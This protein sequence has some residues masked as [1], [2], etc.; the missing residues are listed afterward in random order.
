MY[1]DP[2]QNTYQTFLNFANPELEI[3]HSIRVGDIKG[4]LFQLME[5]FL[6]ISD[7][8][9]IPYRLFS[10]ILIGYL[11]KRYRYRLSNPQVVS[12]LIASLGYLSTFLLSLALTIVLLGR[13]ELYTF[14]FGVT[15]LMV[16]AI[17]NAII[18]LYMLT[19]SCGVNISNLD[20]EIAHA[21][22]E[23][24]IFEHQRIR[25]EALLTLKKFLMLKPKI[26]SE[27]FVYAMTSLI[28]VG[29]KYGYALKNPTEKA[30][31]ALDE[32]TAQ[33]LRLLA[34]SQS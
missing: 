7:L 22:E 13:F 29:S 2:L 1:V 33:A 10:V 20:K 30:F 26:T 14:I 24:K 8:F 28:F 12:Y 27:N 32:E 9:F 3:S 16:L 19:K 34:Y 17:M 4:F 21:V 25:V 23:E 5:S 18:R 31:R 6:T 11:E 15:L